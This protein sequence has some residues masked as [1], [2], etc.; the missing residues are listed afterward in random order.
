MVSGASGARL[1][2]VADCGGSAAGGSA[3]PI[4]IDVRSTSKSLHLHFETYGFLNNSLDYVYNHVTE[5]RR[6]KGNDV[7]MANEDLVPFSVKADDAR[8]SSTPAATS[9]FARWLVAIQAIRHV[10][11]NADH[12][13][14]AHLMCDCG[15]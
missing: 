15:R 13:L 7:P 1:D 11:T 8:S 4:V 9:S 10:P 3:V 2:D 5:Y 12:C 6:T 14:A